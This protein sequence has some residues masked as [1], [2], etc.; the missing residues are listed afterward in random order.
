MTDP[1]TALFG[2]F[3]RVGKVLASPSRLLLLD[4]LSQGE[5]PVETLAEQARLSVT[6]TSNHLRE[7]RATSLVRTRRKGQSVLYRLA[8]PSVHS[9]LR[10]LQDVA[11]DHLAEVRELVRDYYDDPDALEAV[12]AATLRARLD[13]GDVV[14][15]DVRPP[16]E[17]R[18]AHV[19]GALSIP[20]DELDRRLSEIPRDRQ[21]VAYCRGPYCLY[22]RQA[23][24]RL[25]AQGFEAFRMA[26]GVPEWAARGLPVAAGGDK[27]REHDS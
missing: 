22:S 18:S 27:E 1:K 9:L 16:D 15:L 11:F 25:R 5:K 6:N 14:V 26:E 4:L 8:S 20:I 23:V 12:D 3:A 10:A 7:L 13:A 2:Q 17:Y 24:E 21:V 19:A